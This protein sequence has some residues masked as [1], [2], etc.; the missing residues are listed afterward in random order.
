MSRHRILRAGLAGALITG[1]G[2]TGAATAALA[3]ARSSSAES[4]AVKK[5]PK[6]SAKQTKALATALGLP[7]SVIKKGLKGLEKSDAEQE[8]SGP[9]A[10]TANPAL[11]I[12]HFTAFAGA[13]GETLF[14]L[15]VAMAPETGAVSYEYGVGVAIDGQPQSTPNPAAIAGFG[16]VALSRMFVVEAPE[17]AVLALDPAASFAMVETAATALFVDVFVVLRVPD[18]ELGAGSYFLQA[19]GREGDTAESPAGFSIVMGE[20]GS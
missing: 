7:K 9:N 4:V 14:V 6:A 10:L 5:K 1:L 11:D 3:E 12:E 20:L 16:R 15:K 8:Q 19:F 13:D 2:I 17:G 18:S